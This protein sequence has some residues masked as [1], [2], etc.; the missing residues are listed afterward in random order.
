M[1][2]PE[3]E[4]SLCILC[5][6]CRGACPSVFRLNS[7]GYMEVADLDQYPETE[8]DEAIKHCPANCISWVSN[9]G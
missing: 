2:R 9:D 8:V 5:E 7:A 3:I 6:V 4:L 1:S